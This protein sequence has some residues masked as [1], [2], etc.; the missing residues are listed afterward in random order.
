MNKPR[1]IDEA[2]LHAYVD[3]L[4]DEGQRRR[5]EA[6]LTDH[7]EEAAR[8]ADYKRQNELLRR[9]L[10]PTLDEPFPE[11]LK[12]AAQAPRKSPLRWRAV[13]AI[14][15]LLLGMAVGWVAHMPPRL[16]DKQAIVQ[17]L[18]NPARVA[19]VVY[20]PEVLHPVEVDAAQEQH[21]VAWLGK[22]LGTPIK[23]PGLSRL[24]YRLI[25]GRLL[26]SDDGP[27]A[28]FMYESDNGDRLTLYVRR[29]DFTS[30]ETAFR[31]HKTGRISE[32]YWVDGPL[33]YALVGD[34]ARQKLLQA[35]QETYHQL[36][37]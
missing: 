23:A 14:G 19:H 37:L 16:E 20:T 15:W 30:G 26:P 25:G 21:L 27:A 33:G 28:Q 10:D 6:W 1:H 31:Y 12:A 13:A 36:N 32:F 4:L 17:R 11:A 35:A 29:A 34:V 18:A 24:G 2:D 9:A 3:G 8:I 5:I 22:R 7:P